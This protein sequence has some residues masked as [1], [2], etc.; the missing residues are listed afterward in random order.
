MG[1]VAISCQ[2]FEPT[3]L[4]SKCSSCNEFFASNDGLCSSCFR[5][6]RPEDAAAAARALALRAD[7]VWVGEFNAHVF[8]APNRADLVAL[9]QR[10]SL[11]E[12]AEQLKRLDREVAKV[13]IK[14]VSEKKA[15]VVSILLELF[16]DSLNRSNQRNKIDDSVPV[17]EEAWSFLCA[18][19]QRVAEAESLL[20]I[21]LVNDAVRSSF[22]MNKHYEEMIYNGQD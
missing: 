6:L 17:F 16:A 9:Q 5:R 14:A 3:L 21:F 4:M 11:F 22:V 13:F 15:D 1:S 12:D 19:G 20:T 7:N 10:M 2:S 8:P 18:R